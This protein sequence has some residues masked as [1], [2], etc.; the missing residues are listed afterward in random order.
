MIRP[1]PS[2]TQ[3]NPSRPP[4][5]TGGRPL[6]APPSSQR[7]APARGSS[8]TRM[9]AARARTTAHSAFTRETRPH[10][11]SRACA[12]TVDSRVGQPTPE[13]TARVDVRTGERRLIEFVLQPA[14]RYAEEGL[15]ER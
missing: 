6:S 8:G 3:F 14:L 7:G 11:A 5:R 12:V 4:R 1:W 10:R 2:A 13:M 15:M 9:T